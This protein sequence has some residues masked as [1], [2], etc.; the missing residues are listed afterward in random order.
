MTSDRQRAANRRNAQRSTGPR[1]AAGKKRSR[2]NALRH[3]LSAQLGGDPAH[4]RRVEALAKILAGPEGGPSELNHARIVADAT[5]QI[6]QIRSLRATM[7]DPAARQ[8]EVF[9][10]S[11]PKGVRWRR[12]YKKNAQT[13]NFFADL[14]E[15]DPGDGSTFGDRFFKLTAPLERFPTWPSGPDASVQILSRFIDQ[16]V[17]LDRYEAQQLARRKAAF[18]ALDAL[19]ATRANKVS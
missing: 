5:L 11:F 13:F 19:E 14:A 17:T 18:R 1:S 15:Q 16:I 10:A 7:M 3:G 4:D 6:T 8:R 9:S 12:R 2:L